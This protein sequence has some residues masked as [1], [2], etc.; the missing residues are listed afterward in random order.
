M[1]DT[2]EAWWGGIPWGGLGTRSADAYRGL[3]SAVLPGLLRGI[4]G[5]ETI[6][7]ISGM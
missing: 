6:A 5:V 2:F 3:Y 4:L 7:H 1:T